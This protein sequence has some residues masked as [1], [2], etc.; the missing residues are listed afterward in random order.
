VPLQPDGL[1]ARWQEVRSGMGSRV[2]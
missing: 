2:G 1:G